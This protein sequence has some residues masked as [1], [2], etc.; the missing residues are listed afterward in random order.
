MRSSLHGA[1]VRRKFPGHRRRL[2]RAIEQRKQHESSDKAADMSDPGDRH[3]REAEYLSSGAE[4]E[5]RSEPDH[6]EDERPALRKD[7][8]EARSGNRLDLGTTG[9]AIRPKWR[10]RLKHE[11]GRRAH[12]A[13]IRARGADE[14]GEIHR[15]DDPV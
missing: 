9:R 3:V 8:A 11:P 4:D 12:E 15:R 10:S 5:I 6:N 2:E 14:R 1:R 7:A 13:G